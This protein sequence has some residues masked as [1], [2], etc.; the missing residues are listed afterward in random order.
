LHTLIHSLT[1]GEKRNCRKLIRGLGKPGKSQ[2]EALFDALL[3]VEEGN[4]TSLK[5]SIE[6]EG[7][8]RH[9]A[10]LLPRLNQQILKSLVHLKSDSSI[11]AQLYRALSEVK[12]IYDKH[13]NEQGMR[14]ISNARR[15]ARSYSR[16]TIELELLVWEQRFFVDGNPKATDEHLA[17]LRSE[18]ERLVRLIELQ[19]RLRQLQSEAKT[20][21]RKNFKPGNTEEGKLIDSFWQPELFRQARES[22]DLL[23]E[24]LAGSVEGIYHMLHGDFLA[25]YQV[26]LPL[27]GHWERKTAWVED[28]AELLL[29]V[30]NNFFKAA[31]IGTE[32]HE[33]L[34]KLLT[35][36][37][38]FPFQDPSL[39]FRMKRVVYLNDF[40][41][42][43]NFAR[44]ER[45][46]ALARNIE[47]WLPE[48]KER[49]SQSQWISFHYNLVAY[50][51]FAGN[52]SAANRAILTIRGL[53][54]GPILN[55]V[56]T[57][58]ALMQIMVQYEIGNLDQC[59]LLYRNL[60]RSLG[61]RLHPS[62]PYLRTL[63]LYPEILKALPGKALL[64]A[65]A[66][67]ISAVESLDP[68]LGQEEMLIWAKAH[69]NSR[70]ITEEF[71]LRIE[72]SRKK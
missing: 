2:V 6:K 72:A 1:Q 33:P 20:A 37:R 45:G 10:T 68:F 9:L 51:F 17:F 58:A 36:I 22:G 69:L 34:E 28:Q 18:R 70:S 21:D 24:L 19:I 25:A 14:T 7:L 57:L 53:P 54:P 3:Q 12:I 62:S 50:Y 30:F 38:N 49:L 71:R 29:I 23:A 47:A 46:K 63:D 11:D 13:L 43:M 16:A 66:E 64:D 8:T 40:V 48:A 56:R 60:K 27:V 31:I 52:L 32:E 67:F 44:I 5:E 4:A 42:C 39:R 55:N 26:L 61:K 59:E 35:L 41:F 65:F 15:I